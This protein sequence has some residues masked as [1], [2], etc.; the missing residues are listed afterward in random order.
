MLRGRTPSPRGSV[1][2]RNE[3]LVFT[4]C[5]IIEPIFFFYP[6]SL[7]YPVHFSSFAENGR[8]SYLRKKWSRG[9][10]R[11]D[12]PLLPIKPIQYPSLLP[13]SHCSWC[14]VSAFYK[15]I[16]MTLSRLLR[17]TGTSNFLHLAC[18]E[19]SSTTLHFQLP[20]SLVLRLIPIGI[21]IPAP[22]ASLG[23]G[24]CK[25]TCWIVRV[26]VSQ[27]SSILCGEFPAACRIHFPPSSQNFKFSMSQY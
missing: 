12:F 19:F 1:R 8:V 15:E 18:L 4:D 11:S 14:R 25:I 13:A 10:L 17:F 23:L 7:P 9:R 24:L 26:S 21:P 20:A 5:Y 22:L 16:Y 3:A 2:R 27:V 6:F